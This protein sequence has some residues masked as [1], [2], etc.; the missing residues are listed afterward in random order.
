MLIFHDIFRN[1]TP[2]HDFLS[3]K[4]GY[5]LFNEISEIGLYFLFKCTETWKID[6][7]IYKI[8]MIIISMIISSKEQN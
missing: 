7:T 5:K 4:N 1:S 2:C 6:M 8:S 3:K